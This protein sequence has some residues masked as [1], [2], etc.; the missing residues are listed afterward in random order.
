MTAEDVEMV[1]ELGRRA[2]ATVDAARLMFEAQDAVRVRDEF[3]AIAS[4]DMRTPLAAVRGFAQLARR[5]LA[6]DERDL[7]SVDRWLADIDE[8]AG[9]LTGLVSEFMDI[10]LLRGGQSVPLQLQ[11]VDLVE[12]VTD[13]MR[14]HQGS[15]DEQTHTFNVSS[16]AAEIV[17][18]W[19]GARLGRVIDN[20]LSNAAKFSPSGST[21]EIRIWE[22]QGFGCVAV[23]DD[24]IGIAF[25]DQGLIFGPMYRAQNARGVSGTGLGLAGARSLLELMGGEITV[26]SRIGEG[27]TFTIRVPLEPDPQSADDAESG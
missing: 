20:V 5:N 3:M 2:G 8:S 12:L 7:A 10:S 14:Q 25:R 22:E 9:R 27:S 1:T 26:Q 24:G 11:R 13:R 6:K 23:A 4:H 17:G 16:G 15:D 18:N 21:I 19:D